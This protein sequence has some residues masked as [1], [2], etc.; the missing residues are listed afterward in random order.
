MTFNHN[1]KEMI[2]IITSNQMTFALFLK[3][4][5]IEC[6]GTFVSPYSFKLFPP[7]STV[8]TPCL[9]DHSGKSSR[10]FLAY[11][12]LM[13]CVSRPSYRCCSTSLSFC[14]LCKMLTQQCCMDKFASEG[15]LRSSSRFF[16]LPRSHP[17]LASA[18]PL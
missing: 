1:L 18:N 11:Y 6:S 9:I 13:A 7:L 14:Y 8:Y 5:V 12:S 2:L 4:E 3:A 17:F 10:F 16:R 15:H